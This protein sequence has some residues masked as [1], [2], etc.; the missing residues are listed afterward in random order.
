MS[1]AQQLHNYR[2]VDDYLKMI[3]RNGLP[4]NV[5]SELCERVNRAVVSTTQRVCD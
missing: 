1:S 2:Y 4:G 5:K 3:N